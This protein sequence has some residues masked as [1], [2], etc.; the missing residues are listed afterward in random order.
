[1]G[2]EA[3]VGAPTEEKIRAGQ[4]EFG[5]AV[6]IQVTGYERIDEMRAFERLDLRLQDRLE[7]RLARAGLDREMG[8]INA[9]NGWL[10]RAGGRFPIDPQIAFD[11][12]PL[13]TPG[14]GEVGREKKPAL[15][16][17][18]GLVEFE[19]IVAKFDLRQF[20]TLGLPVGQEL[21]PLA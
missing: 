21:T 19:L 13:R 5:K 3:T 6:A 2:G 9:A 1:M 11:N 10:T 17:A 18:V 8:G 14:I 16:G 15:L 12:G 4:N 20:P 7:G